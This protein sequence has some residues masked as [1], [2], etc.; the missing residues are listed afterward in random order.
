[1]TRIPA[2]VLL[3]FVILIFWPAVQVAALLIFRMRIQELAIKGMGR[4]GQPQRLALH[5]P[6]WAKV[7]GGA[8][9]AVGFVV[10]SQHQLR[11]IIEKG[12][13]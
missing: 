1:M 4:L 6:V 5:V 7:V 3:A 11:T 9:L 8:L 2:P 12:L 10:A 13:F